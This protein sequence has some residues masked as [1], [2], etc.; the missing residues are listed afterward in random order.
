[1][2]E[3]LVPVRV[4][5][6][7]GNTV[8]DLRKE[9]FQVFDN[10]KR[11]VISGFMVA[12]S[13]QP[14]KLGTPENRVNPSSTIGPRRFVV[15][16]F[17]DMH[18]SSA[19]LARIQEAAIRILSTS[20]DRSDMAAVAS[21]SGSVNSGLTVDRAKLQDAIMKLRPQSLY[22][23]TGTNCPNMDYYQAELIVNEHSSGA[24]EMA[25]D[26]VM[27][28]NPNLNMRD[29]ARRLAQSAAEREFA[30]GEQDTQV[31]LAS[32]REF[33]RRI[34]ALPGMSTLILVSPGFLTLTAHARDEESQIIDTAALSNITINALDA[35]GLYTTELDASDR[36]GGSTLTTH[37]KSEY[38]RASMPLD[39]DIMAELASG[40]G[41]TYFHN[42]NDLEGGLKRL[43]STPEYLYL[44]EF[45]PRNLKK[46][47]G[48]HHLQVKVDRDGLKVQAR[49]GYFIPK[50]TKASK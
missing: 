20:L 13:P 40:T 23:K 2:N 8:G 15:F 29:V 45:Y 10:N 1:M 42:S 30:T 49:R 16:L 5:D 50:A 14:R 3:I 6:R 46:N 11:Q 31:S 24:L 27:N 22:R 4:D 39:E 12:A 38:H 26:E 48:Y 9:D 17:D 36:G 33:V 21:V 25:T 32:L 7:G 19:D 18:L 43:T 37:A 34:A 28:C 35:R 41:G 44:L 47:G